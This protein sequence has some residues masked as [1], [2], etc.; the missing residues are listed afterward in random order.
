MAGSVAVREKALMSTSE[1]S[2]MIL[3]V[4][5]SPSVQ[6]EEEEEVI[7]SLE[8]SEGAEGTITRDRVSMGR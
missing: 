8:G 7:F 2:Q 3:R 1:G 6:S 5:L 4:R